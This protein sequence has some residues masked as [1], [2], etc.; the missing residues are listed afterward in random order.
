M[1]WK[2]NPFTDSLDQTGSGGGSYIDGEVEYHSN[3]PVTAGTPAVNSAFLVRKGEGLYFLTRKPAGIWVRELNNGNLNDWKYAGTFSDLYRDANFRILNNTDVTKELAFDV[4]GVATGT[5]R[6]LTV[7]NESGSIQLALVVTSQFIS[8]NT[9]LSAGRNR[10]ITLSAVNQTVNVDL[11]YSG[12]ADGDVVTLVASSGLF[13]GST[14]SLRTASGMS[15]GVPSTYAALATLTAPDQSFTFVSDGT[16]TGWR[17]RPVDTHTH[18]ASQITGTFTALAANNGTIT[19]SAPVLDLAQTWNQNAACEF[20]GSISATTL[21]VS[22]VAS[23][24]LQ[25]GSEIY[26]SSV[27]AGTFITALGTGTG[28]TGTYT[29]SSS[30][31]RSGTMFSKGVF[32]ASRLQITDTASSLTSNFLDLRKG[33]SSQLFIRHDGLIGWSGAS[34]QVA[35]WYDPSLGLVSYGPSFSPITRQNTGFFVLNGTAAL[36]WGS[37]NSVAGADTSLFRDAADTLAQRRGTNFQTFRLYSTYTDGSNYERGFMRWSGAGGTLQI[38]T[39]ALGTGSSRALEL[40]TGGTTRF[41]IA[42]NGAI[43][44][45]SSLSVVSNL[46]FQGNA[47]IVGNIASGVLRLVA[48]SGLTDFNRLQFGGGTASFP[49][50]KRSSTVLQARLADDSDFCPLQGQLRIHQNA[51]AE[52]PTAT[53]TMTLFDAAGTAYKVLCV[54]A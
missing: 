27:V 30:Q 49:A 25:V 15:G 9:A 48:A 52:T 38:G 1:P 13:T 53:H 22:A 33:G 45:S 18:A 7:P 51:V 8:A 3:L 31:T 29:V 21:T 19:A 39:E 40:Q 36:S 37:G 54:A 34:P 41:T 12:N 50:L 6:T 46:F 26:G 44:C 47:A 42:T 16:A 14:L 2:Y 32:T 28:T 5:T 10:R 23:G 35:L 24:T 4:S 20:T 17:L 43:I 11:P